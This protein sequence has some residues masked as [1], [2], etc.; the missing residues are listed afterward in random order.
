MASET[1]LN[2]T[3]L[4]QRNFG[5]FTAEEQARIRKTRILIVGD[6]GVGETLATLLARS[7][8]ERFVL[9]GQDT[10]EPADMNRQPC[11]FTN[12]LGRR[13]ISIISDCLKAINPGIEVDVHL[14][15][16]EPAAIEGLVS[17]ADIVIPAVDDLA[18]SVLCFRLA[19]KNGK[20]AILCM[21]SGAMGLVSVFTPGSST[22]EDCLGIPNLDYEGLAVVIRT[23]EFKCSQYNYITA[24]SWR[25][26]WYRD[27]FR[28]KNPLAQICAVEWLVASLAGLETLKVA[29]G[30]WPFTEAP[31]CWSIKRGKVSN[32]H[33]SRFIKY[34][35]KLGWLIFGHP[36]GRPLHR[37]TNLFWRRF[38]SY[39]QN[40]QHRSG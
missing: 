18:Y 26:E 21:P 16:P 10:Y 37:W 31:L 32:S 24:G 34:H 3:T 14:A 25:V 7:G 19:K 9:V 22:L 4:F 2:Y 38:F 11:C 6:S 27:Y 8:C 20:T 12:T 17:Q 33:F 13:K 40:R 15:L 23:P 29:S 30:K 35:R 1:P 36:W 39:L 5:I 28:G